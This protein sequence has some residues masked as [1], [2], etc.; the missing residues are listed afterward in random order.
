MLLYDDLITWENMLP[1]TFTRSTAECRVGILTIQEKWEK[2][3]NSPVELE[4]AKDYLK[5]TGGKISSD[6]KVV[7]HILPN[8]ELVNAIKSL[9]ENSILV[10]ENTEIASKNKGINPTLIA[11]TGT[12]SFIHFPWDIFLQ[13]DAEIRKDFE[14]IT[15]VRTSAHIG[16][17]NK[18]L[19]ENIFIEPDAKV[20]CSIIN[21]N[22]G[23]VYIG[24][25]AEVMEGAI[26][27]GPFSLGENAQVKMGAKIY[28]ATTIGPGCKV[29][30]EITNSV[31]FANSNKAHDGYI[32]NSVLGEW[33]NLGADTNSSNLKNNYSM[34]EIYNYHKGAVIETS[35]QFLG[36]IMGDHS[37]SGIN[38]MFNTGTVV[39]VCANIVG[40]GFPKKHIP[41]FSWSISEKIR[42][43]D[44]EKA[45]ETIHVVYGR[46][47]K[48]L[49]EREEFIL[50][51]I[52][53]LTISNNPA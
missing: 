9:H 22:T 17:D 53:N 7:S 10:H 4:Y 23:P 15:A 33:C 38:T 25:N 39:G 51:T 8:M 41:S 3:F 42:P 35:Q 40:A 47:N 1:L 31:F 24:K 32:G 46:R 26:I 28:G 52:Y 13:N 12:I 30:G 16:S 44:L 6:I 50:R 27:R 45:F 11:Y 14:L 37:K 34:V 19:G 2:Y 36:L 5:N 20:H 43:Y 21:T 49:T 29:G 48:K 18:I